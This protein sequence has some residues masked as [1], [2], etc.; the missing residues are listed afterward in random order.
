MPQGAAHLREAS[1][2]IQYLAR[3]DVQLKGYRLTRGLPTRADAI[4]TLLPD[5]LPNIETAPATDGP[6]AVVL[7]PRRMRWRSRADDRGS[8]QLAHPSSLSGLLRGK[9][10]AKEVGF[11]FCFCL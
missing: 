5:H 10:L 7:C 9:A 8:C 4:Q 6:G 1:E 2:F 11:D 3:A